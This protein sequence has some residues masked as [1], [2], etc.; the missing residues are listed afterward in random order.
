MI[1][2]GLSGTAPSHVSWPL[3]LLQGLDWF[4]PL[5]KETPVEL[6]WECNSEQQGILCQST[7][8]FSMEIY[9][10]LVYSKS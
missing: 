6:L 7:R 5:W 2:S 3:R 8:K 1:I 10:S 9:R 4:C